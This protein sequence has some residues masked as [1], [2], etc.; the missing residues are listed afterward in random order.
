MILFVTVAKTTVESIPTEGLHFTPEHLI[1]IIIGF[2][3][4]GLLGP[5]LSARRIRKEAKAEKE[6]ADKLEAAD[7]E[8]AKLLKE[9]DEAVA[10]AL[11]AKDAVLKEIDTQWRET[12]AESFRKVEL[13]N[14]GIDEKLTSFCAQNN[15]V[16]AELIKTKNDQERRMVKIEET[17]HQRGCDQPYLRRVGEPAV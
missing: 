16:H 2:L 1:S 3:L 17:H 4:M 6:R 9:R 7:A 13:A 5:V 12:V 15:I 10:A 8:R 11:K 14:K